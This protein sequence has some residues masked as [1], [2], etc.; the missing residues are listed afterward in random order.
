MAAENDYGVPYLQGTDPLGYLDE[1]SLSL[2]TALIRPAAMNV[3]AEAGWAYVAQNCV[4]LIGKKLLWLDIQFT[5]TG[6]ALTMANDAAPAPGNLG[7]TPIAT[8]TM[9]DAPTRPAYLQGNN[10]S[11]GLYQCVLNTAKVL[12]LTA[13]PTSGVIGVNSAFTVQGLVFLG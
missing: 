3:V 11:I 12:S 13:G 9:A 8:L 1:H 7:D 6:A 2:A 10:S 5:R 4:F